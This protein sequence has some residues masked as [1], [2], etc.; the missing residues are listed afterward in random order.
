MART[1]HEKIND[2]KEFF[3][4]GRTLTYEYR[5]SSLLKLKS[6][7][8]ENKEEIL[9]ALKND[10]NKSYHEG[11]MTEY[12]LVMSE[13][14]LAIKKLKKWM[15]PERK[16]A[17]LSQMP[18]STKIHSDP[19][20]LVLVMSPWNY[21]FQ[22]CIIPIISAIA[23]GNTVIVKPSAYSKHTTDIIEK[24]R[25]VMTFPDRPTEVVFV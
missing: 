20:G 8:E 18:A 21:P 7:L 2:G 4:S 15:K 10:L 24:T 3:N 25:F 1:I 17:A 14:S 23:A 5:K 6:V 16:K 19:Y 11:F 22:L 12:A 13:L 9:E